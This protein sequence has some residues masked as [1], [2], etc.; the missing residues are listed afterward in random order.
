MVM[1]VETQVCPRQEDYLHDLDIHGRLS[2]RQITRLNHKIGSEKTVSSRLRDLWHA[3]YVDREHVPQNHPHGNLLLLYRLKDK[4]IKYVKKTQHL[5][6][7]DPGKMPGGFKISP[8]Q[9][10]KDCWIATRLLCK[11]NP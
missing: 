1:Q 5:I 6:P 10:V 8:S 7:R 3:E 2:I 4:G 11:E 9:E